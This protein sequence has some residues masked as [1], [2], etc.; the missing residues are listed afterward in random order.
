MNEYT[1]PLALQDFMPVALSSA[2][3]FFLAEMIARTNQ[4]TGRV[5]LFGAWL[6]MLGG[7]LKAAWKLNMA[8]SG[9][10]V[11][12]MSNALF[13]LLAPGFTLMACA[14]WSAQAQMR[15]RPLRFNLSAIAFAIG[16]VSLAVAA[17]LSLAVPSGSAWKFILLGVTTI[18]NLVLSARCIVQ[19][20]R[21]GRRDVAALFIVNIV[22]VIILQGLARIP[23]QTI[24]LQWTEQIINTL[25]GAAFAYAAWKLSRE[26]Q[27]RLVAGRLQFA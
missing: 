4:A 9:N 22:A 5:A 26:T 7:G 25:S 16:G 2:G 17:A 1:I 6:I 27:A 8:M 12:W 14:L 24:P 21:M 3:L 18:A 19:A 23:Q 11:A 15:G 13:V 20:A 10:D